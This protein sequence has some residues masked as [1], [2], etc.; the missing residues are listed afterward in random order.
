MACVR[1]CSWVCPSTGPELTKH[2]AR[3]ALSS[4][5]FLLLGLAQPGC[6]HASLAST[7]FQRPTEKALCY[8]ERL[9]G[10]S[11]S[12][13]FPKIPTPMLKMEDYIILQLASPI[14]LLLRGHGHHHV[15]GNRGQATI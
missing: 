3:S 11:A 2:L 5:V 9:F 6:L 14:S 7:S 12:Q 15:S 8:P 10:N 4:I 13:F 1:L